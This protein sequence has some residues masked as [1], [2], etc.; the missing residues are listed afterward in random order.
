[1]NP[2]SNDPVYHSHPIRKVFDDLNGL[3]DV[4]K[5]KGVRYPL[6]YPTRCRIVR[7]PTGYK[8]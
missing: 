1:M 6:T 2:Y 7:D 8:K 5:R 3:T 4:V